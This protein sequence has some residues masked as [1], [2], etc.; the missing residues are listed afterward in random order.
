MLYEYPLQSHYIQ[1]YSNIRKHVRA[2]MDPI[3]VTK[4]F[5]FNLSV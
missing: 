5:Y 1:D 3:L 2:D 4:L